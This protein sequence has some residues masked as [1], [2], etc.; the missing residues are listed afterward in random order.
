MMGWV[1]IC[2]NLII[3]CVANESESTSRLFE[4]SA[5]S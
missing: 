1:D 2:G 3:N 5:E 4:E